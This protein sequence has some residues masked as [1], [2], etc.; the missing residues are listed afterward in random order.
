MTMLLEYVYLDNI[1]RKK[2]AQSSHEYLITQVQEIIFDNVSP[3]NSNFEL[4]FFHCCKELYWSAVQYESINNIYNQNNFDKFYID[5]QK[6]MY[7][8][9]KLNYL[10]YLNIVYNPYIEYDPFNYI[11]GYPTAL[12]VGEQNIINF[13]NDINSIIENTNY[14]YSYVTS[15][16]RN[17]SIL[18]NSATL[19]NQ[20]NNFFNYLEPYNYYNNTPDLGVNT[21]S[22]SINPT[23]SQ[24]SGS[25]NL[26]RI[27]KTSM[28]F[29]ILA[30]KQNLNSNDQ[31]NQ[32]DTTGNLSNYNLFNYKLY[33]QAVNYNVLRFIGGIVGVA[34]TY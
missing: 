33:I 34:F 9:N 16:I 32:I 23:E 14:N 2:F 31:T 5:L 25:C 27:P 21:Y 12:L 13:T 15:P 17:S 29:D 7:S 24:P 10:N 6:P 18:L 26:S 30:S 19:I 11:S 28:Q 1:E 20:S 22:F 3:T 4:N 8:V